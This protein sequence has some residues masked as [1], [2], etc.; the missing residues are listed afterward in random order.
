MRAPASE[1]LVVGRIPIEAILAQVAGSKHPDGL[2][3]HC[4]RCADH[5]S[6]A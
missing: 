6:A 5:T 2:S 4:K 1:R 3:L